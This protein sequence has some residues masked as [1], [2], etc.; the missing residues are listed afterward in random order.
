MIKVAQ[1]YCVVIGRFYLF[2]CFQWQYWW[3]GTGEFGLAAVVCQI[4]V[5]GISVQI[6]PNNCIQ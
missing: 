3:E 6:L 1:I 2:L 4:N 5:L